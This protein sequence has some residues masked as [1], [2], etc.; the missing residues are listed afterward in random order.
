MA[1]MPNTVDSLMQMISSL[2][3]QDP[4]TTLAESTLLGFDTETTGARPGSDAIVSATLVLRN[5]HL[6][7]DA[8]QAAEW[9]VNP[10]RR[11]SAGATR[12]NG[13]TD[14]F[15]GEHGSEPTQAL[16]QLAGIIAAAQRRN[17]PLLAYNAPFD[18]D[19][20]QGDLR[21]WKLT[22]LAEL[23]DHEILV[24]DPLVLDRAVS[25]RHGRR[26]LGDTTEYYGVQPHGD[27]HN[28]TA[29]TVAAIDLIKPMTTLYPQLAHLS[30][31]ELMDWQRAANDTWVSS[32][33]QWLAS[34]GRQPIG[35]DWFAPA[36][37]GVS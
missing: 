34:R 4:S 30:L 2:E 32:Y 8:D 22:P 33:N 29:D 9:L 3:K 11:M 13:F 23:T 16:T 5:P 17:I 31:N 36:S 15:L 14:D 7:Y 19:M 6:G 21:R 12:V 35:R 28:A 27:F 25:K 18:V 10:H 1:H 20:L 24:V 37:H 26:T